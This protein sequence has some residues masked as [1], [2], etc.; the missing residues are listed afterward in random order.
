M[1]LDAPLTAAVTLKRSICP[2]CRVNKRELEDIPESHRWERRRY[3]P[4]CRPCLIEEGYVLTGMDVRMFGQD[5]ELYDYAARWW[6][7]K[8][9]PVQRDD[10]EDVFALFERAEKG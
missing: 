3:S 10:D 7:K 2:R 8:S 4:F 1:T 6:V 5:G 9:D